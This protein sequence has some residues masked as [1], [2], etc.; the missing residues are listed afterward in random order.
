MSATLILFLV[1]ISAIH[2]VYD[3]IML[4]S[5]RQRQR[6]KLFILR[7]RLRN[8]MIE[9]RGMKPETLK[10]FKQMDD[11]INL[12]VN[13]LHLFTFT[14]F[15]KFQVNSR[16]KKLEQ[17]VKRANKFREN[18]QECESSIPREVHEELLIE[19]KNVLT[20]NSL[21]FVLWLAPLVLLVQLVSLIFTVMSS[22]IKNANV[23][24]GL[25]RASDDLGDI[26]TGSR[27]VRIIA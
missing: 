15:V 6:D 4:P 9:N 22:S 23:F 24:S 25:K 13:R 14:N 2:Y 11:R 20:M 19:L 21:L 3:R 12:A 5:M 16:E 18:L 17:A 27:D 26:V 8:E 10:V 7:D 1:V